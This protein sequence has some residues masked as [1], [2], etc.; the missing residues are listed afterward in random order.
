M[1]FDIEILIQV[2][3]VNIVFY[4][5]DA[6]TNLPSLW[7]FNHEKQLFKVYSPFQGL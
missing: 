2:C 1:L 5:S 7:L 3:F 4:F 6:N